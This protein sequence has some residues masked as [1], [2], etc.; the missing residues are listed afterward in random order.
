MQD[1]LHDPTQPER[2]SLGFL[3]IET[4]KTLM[5]NTHFQL[6][7]KI[8]FTS[9]FC[10]LYFTIVHGP[11]KIATV[12]DQTYPSCTDSSGGHSERLLNSVS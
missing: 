4:F 10:C 6:Q 8:D 12:H 2:S 1:E 3:F 11:L 5:Y 7:M 9:A